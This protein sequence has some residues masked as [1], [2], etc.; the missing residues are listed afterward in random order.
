MD[1]KG[2]KEVDPDAPRVRVF[3]ARF[4]GICLAALVL[5]LVITGFT[6]EGFFARM[7]DYL[8]SFLRLPA[9]KFFV[10]F[11]LVVFILARLLKFGRFITHALVAV[12]ALASLNWASKSASG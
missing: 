3:F 10:V 7:G 9:G 6:E 2:V 8:A 5:R 4:I 11:T 1:R 12:G